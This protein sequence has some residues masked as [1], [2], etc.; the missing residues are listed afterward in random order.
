MPAHDYPVRPVPFTAVQ[1]TV[2]LGAAH[3]DQPH[4]DDSL[5]VRQERGDGRVG[6]F[7]R[8]AAVLQGHPPADLKPPGYPFDDTDIYKVLEGASYTLS[9]KP[10]PKLSGYLDGL[11]ETI[12]AAQEK[13]GYLYTTRTIDPLHPHPWAG[14]SRWVNETDLSHELY[15]LGHLYEAA[16]AH[17][18]A[19]GK[20]SL[21]DV[22]LRTADLL[23]ATFGP[24][25]QSIWPGH[26]ITEMGLAKLYRVTGD[27]QYLALAKFMLDARGPWQAGRAA[28]HVQPVARPRRRPDRS[29]RTCGARDLH[30]FRN[31]RRRGAH[32]RSA[33]TSTPSIGS[34]T[35]RRAKAVHDR[36][37]RLA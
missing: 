30:V 25:K 9:V 24:G 34:G 2:I 28:G 6:N 7:Q 37:H 21:L 12:A 8:A 17:Y 15:N 10:D 32:G 13:D 19:T 29:G 16:V 20:R 4:G 36:R 26:Q 23:V 35:T 31:G 3:R 1:V 33:A 22:A 18:Q 5:R 11:I 27:E 14:A